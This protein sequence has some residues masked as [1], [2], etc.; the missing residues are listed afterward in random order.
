MNGLPTYVIIIPSLTLGGA[1]KQAV[2]YARALLRTGIAQPFVLGL[3]R[4]GRLVDRLDDLD[5]PHASF[6]ASD[7]FGNNRFRKAWAVLRFA[8]FL[9]SLRPDTIIGFTH[10]P[11]L[12]GGL[13]WRWSGARRF[14]WNQRSVDSDVAMTMWER[15]AI[16]LRPLYISNGLAGRAF[17]M[18][19]H[20]LHAESVAII[21]NAVHLPEL[22]QVNHERTDD[23]GVVH[24]LM[25]ANFFP[26]KDHATLLR[27]L[28]MYLDRDDARPV[29]LH[30]VGDAPGISP[31]LTLMKALT[32]DLRLDHQ[33]IFH[34]KLANMAPIL[35]SAHIG[36]LSTRS[37][38]VSNA[39]LEYMAYGLPV[40]ATDIL[41]NR[42]ALGP[43]NEQWLFPVG[44]AKRLAELL[45]ELIAHPDRATIGQRN[46]SYVELQNALPVFDH[47]LKHVVAPTVP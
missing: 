5:I 14:I 47:A 32:F 45:A 39:V 11:N 15:M 34:G 16:R 29:Q 18:E 41:A 27:A 46:R 23:N 43:G 17:L 24:L 26:E 42:E 6:D 30:L 44:N 20:G 35:S 36:I 19:R 9:R 4:D 28:R 25:T 3:G 2:H 38:G 33:V 13:A 8:W 22:Q 40:I 31:A 10:W 7:F 1:E 12:L 37:E 21:P